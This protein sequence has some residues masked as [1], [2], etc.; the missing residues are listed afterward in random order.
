MRGPCQMAVRLLIS[1]E[2]LLLEQST[3]LHATAVRSTA[4]GPAAG[5]LHSKHLLVLLGHRTGAGT[6]GSRDDMVSVTSIEKV[7]KEHDDL[8]NRLYTVRP[9]V[10]LVMLH[11]VMQAIACALRIEAHRTQRGGRK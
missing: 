11:C 9:H 5:A 7:D 4:H 6:W 10:L 8:D 3:A 1:P 2:P